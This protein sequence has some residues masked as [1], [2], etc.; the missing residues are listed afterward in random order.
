M[1]GESFDIEEFRVDP[2]DFQKDDTRPTISS[3]YGCVSFMV[4]KNTKIPCAVKRTNESLLGVDMKRS[5]TREIETLGK[6]QHPAIVPFIGFAE[7]NNFGYIYLVEMKNGSLQTILEKAR[8]GK[9]ISGF[10]QTTKY[11]VS[12]GI[13]CSMKYLHSLNRIHRDLKA[14]NVLLDEQLRPFLTDFGTAKEIDKSIPINQTLSATTPVIMAPEFIDDPSTFSNSLPIDVYSYGITLY[15][16]WTEMLPF[17]HLKGLFQIYTA[18]TNGERPKIPISLS[19]NWA[20]LIEKCWSHN[21][22]DRPTFHEIV[23]MLESDEYLTSDINK[24][25][26]AK[27]RRFLEES[28]LNRSWVV[29]GVRVTARKTKYEDTQDVEN[30]VLTKMRQDA[31]NGDIEARF[32]YVIAQFGGDY[33]NPNHKEALK[34]ALPYINRQNATD[35]KFVVDTATIE[36]YA[37]KCYSLFEKYTE[38]QKLLKRAVNH[39]NAEAAFYLA[40][41]IF[42]GKVESRSSSELEMLYK[43]AADNGVAEAIKKYA[44]MTYYG[45]FN[46]RPDKQKAIEYFHKGSDLGDSELMYIWAIRNEYGRNIEKNVKEAMRLMKL[47]ADNGYTPAMVDYGIHLLNGINVEKNED[48][49]KARFEAAAINEDSLGE[50]YYSVMLSHDGDTESASKYL[51]GCLN[52]NEVPEAWSVYGRQLVEEGN[53]QDALPS[54][55]YAAQNGS[56]NAFLCLGELCEK[57]PS[58]GDANFFFEA[59]SNFCHCLDEKGFFTPISYKVYHCYGCNID[60]CEGCAK[61][62][63]Q[64]HNV[65]YVQELSG[66]TCACGKNG[67]KDHCSGEYVGESTGYQHL[68]QCET[69]CMK[70]DQEFICKSCAEKCHKGH[71][72]IDC[73]VQRNFCSCGMKQIPHNFKCR[74][75]DF[76][77]MKRPYQHCS[78]DKKSTNIRQRWFQCI[79]CGL[80]GSEDTGV[81]KACSVICHSDHIVLDLGVKEKCC[82]CHNT[83]CSFQDK[84]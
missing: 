17:P 76:N 49:A 81:C 56:I 19:P 12:Y 58:M 44:Y 43:R 53:D 67:F 4:Q 59:A 27:Y 42:D 62:C 6:C 32:N 63:H 35:K 7:K 51:T 8:K 78:I 16:L 2:D 41:L 33:G 83:G 45:T 1:D 24:D 14:G 15:E 5:F 55:Y 29:S 36:F 9:R 79:S 21:P 69:C 20:K 26:V 10:D 39:G 34:Y 77:D 52:T 11:I 40:E 70:S 50:L 74:L 80:Y 3:G 75:L 47:S 48:E 23:E 57:N 22:D 61:H 13:A 37:G 54:L 82:C 64:G 30:P 71:Q 68:Y 72:I 60:I 65:D 38:A 25:E 66:F 28:S 31:D 84:S 18:V 73:G 46:G